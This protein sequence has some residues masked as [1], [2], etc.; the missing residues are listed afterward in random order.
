MRL[1]FALRSLNWA[2]SWLFLAFTLRA[3]QMGEHTACMGRAGVKIEPQWP[4]GLDLSETDS[5]R[6][7]A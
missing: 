1:S 2:R 3:A 5:I 6:T 4:Q 7:P